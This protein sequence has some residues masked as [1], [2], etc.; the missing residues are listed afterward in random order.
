LTNEK[1][2]FKLLPAKG[3]NILKITALNEGRIALNT[4][5]VELFSRAFHEHYIHVLYKNQHAQYEINN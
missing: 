2:V 3:K 4:S 5:K 1:V